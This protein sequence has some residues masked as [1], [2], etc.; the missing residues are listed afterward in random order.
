MCGNDRPSNEQP[1][2]QA[3]VLIRPLLVWTAD[4]WL[5]NLRQIW[6]IK[7]RS[8][9]LTASTTSVGEP[10]SVTRTGASESPYLSALETR[11]PS[12]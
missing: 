8:V 2:A 10:V 11:L 3:A 12:N 7:D 9:V 4:E 1:Q 6:C 5:E